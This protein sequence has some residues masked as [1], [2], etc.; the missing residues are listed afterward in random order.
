MLCYRIHESDT[1]PDRIHLG[2]TMETNP[3]Q[4]GMY[5]GPM[6][7]I[8]WK[9]KQFL[10]FSNGS[11]KF[12]CFYDPLM[13]QKNCFLMKNLKNPKHLMAKSINPIPAHGLI[14][15]YV[16]ICSWTLIYQYQGLL[17]MFL[18]D[19]SLWSRYCFRGLS[20]FMYYVVAHFT[21]T[22]LY[23][24]HRVQENHFIVYSLL[25]GTRGCGSQ[26]HYY[27]LLQVHAEMVFKII[28]ITT[29]QIISY[30]TWTLFF[31][32]N[33][34]LFVLVISLQYPDPGF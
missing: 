31:G 10:K 34:Y 1:C 25:I 9:I 12:Q 3:L 17:L 27:D 30:G 29:Y 28:N 11:Y 32:D 4:K 2:S 23:P 18:F 33:L 14:C 15:P 7:R 8:L 13:P 20:I 22:V 26:K 16:K 24:C 21:Y 19:W 6:K 5:P